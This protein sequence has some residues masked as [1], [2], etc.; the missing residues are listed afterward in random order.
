MKRINN[1]IRDQD[2]FALNLIK[3]PIKRHGLLTEVAAQESRISNGPKLKL[4][5]ANVPLD[6]VVHGTEANEE[7]WEDDDTSDTRNLLVR[8]LSIRGAL[9][10]QGQ[11]A[12]NFLHKMDKDLQSIV[13]ST[14]SRK[15]TLEEVTESLTCRRIYPL[16]RQKSWLSGA[17]CGMRWWSIM[18]IMLMIGLLMPTVY[19]LYFKYVKPDR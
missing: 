12:E 8:T 18:I 5:E 17:D 2:F 11:E 15:K 10:N 14:K 1:L 16:Q 4:G 9:S 13:A 3:V 19:F 6:C 7:E